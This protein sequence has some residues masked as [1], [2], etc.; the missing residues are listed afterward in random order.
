MVADVE[1]DEQI[2]RAT[3]GRGGFCVPFDLTEVVDRGH[4]AGGDDTADFG[5]VAE[6]TGEQQPGETL[7]GHGL[8]FG[9]SGYAEARGTEG[10]LTAGNFRALVGFNVGPQGAP[11]GVDFAGHA[12]Q[13][14]LEFIQIQSQRG[15]GDFKTVHELDILG[16]PCSRIVSHN[17]APLR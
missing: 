17:Y 6:G 10:Q 9:H 5:R 4:G 3:G 7:A 8:C 14:T 12:L 1:I 13:I 2:D 11:G 16:L 15:G